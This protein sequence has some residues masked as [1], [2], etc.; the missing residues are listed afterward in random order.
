MPI[1]SI[2]ILILSSSL[3]SNHI[4]W[5]IHFIKLSQI[6]IQTGRRLKTAMQEYEPVFIQF[7]FNTGIL[8]HPFGQQ[9]HYLLLI[10][11]SYSIQ[12]GYNRIGLRSIYLNWIQF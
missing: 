7:M 11:I 1:G 6:C 9:T 8:V 2:H 12:V 10:F 5:I 4:H 3:P